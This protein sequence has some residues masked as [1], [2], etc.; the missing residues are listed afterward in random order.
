MEEKNE[1]QTTQTALS[2][3]E[4]VADL[5]QKTDG[6]FD[7]SQ[8]GAL[9]DVQERYEANEARKAYH[10]AMAAFHADAPKIIKT[11]EGHN[12]KHADLAVDL[13]AVVAPKLSSQGLSHSWV[14]KT[15]NDEVT[16]TCKIT[17]VLG[18]SEETTLSAGPDTSGSKNAIQAIGSTITY[19]ERYTLKAALGLAEAGQ[20]DDGNASGKKTVDIPK[21]TEGE[22]D[23]IDKICGLIEA[24][25]GMC[26]DNNRVAMYMFSIN[27][28]HPPADIPPSKAEAAARSIQEK[29]GQDIYV[30]FE[31]K[32][33]L[34][35]EDE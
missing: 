35:A 7:V 30:T 1:I 4:M 19:L 28:K 2:P 9:L 18:H 25:K 34:E 6:K 16:V 26:V 11:K 22:Q 10:V 12:S 33:D 5:M 8:L 29:A 32:H 3:V 13:V 17:H 31:E 27:G 24:P 15:E 14:T 23:M 20:D 21:P